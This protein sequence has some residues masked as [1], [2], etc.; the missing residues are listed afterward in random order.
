M[1]KDD[2]GDTFIKEQMRGKLKSSESDNSG[3]K[4]Q[5][6]HWTQ[7]WLRERQAKLWPVEHAAEKLLEAKTAHTAWLHVHPVPAGKIEPESLTGTALKNSEKGMASA[8]A[9]EDARIAPHYWQSGTFEQLSSHISDHD[10]SE[11][12]FF[13]QRLWS[14]AL[15]ATFSVAYVAYK[16]W[17]NISIFASG[18]RST[19]QGM[20]IRVAF[21]MLIEMEEKYKESFGGID[22][23]RDDVEM[24]FEQSMQLSTAMSN[25]ATA[26]EYAGGFGLGIAI[27]VALFVWLLL[28]ATFRR[29]SLNLRR[30]GQCENIVLNPWLYAN[31][32]VPKNHFGSRFVFEFLGIAVANTVVSF[33]LIGYV[34]TFVFTVL[35][36]DTSRMALWSSIKSVYV[37]IL[38]V[39]GSFAAKTVGVSVAYTYSSTAD[40]RYITDQG[41]FGFLDFVLVFIGTMSGY[42]A[43]IMRIGI[44]FITMLVGFASLTTP[45]APIWLYNSSAIGL[46]GAVRDKVVSS[47]SC[48]LYI[49]NMQN[50]PISH[51]FMWQLMETVRTT[52]PNAN[53][54]PTQKQK[55]IRNR[56]QLYV[57][58]AKYPQLRAYR[59]INLSNEGG[60]ASS[61]SPA[62]AAHVSH[63]A[64]CAYE[65][66]EYQGEAAPSRILQLQGVT[67][68]ETAFVTA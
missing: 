53:S 67:T 55:Q 68:T 26:I 30:T 44:S 23:A 50:N 25:L 54:R 11:A 61:P 34:L 62:P 38:V 40:G 57:M 10:S 19:N 33:Q 5:H 6:V 52:A 58:L 18:F 29:D 15:I 65:L 63:E 8:I 16:F 13:P 41:V 35:I 17:T 32:R 66:D 45:V 47:Y 12:F 39:L 49:H 48:M 56:F 2:G 1:P 36:W 7:Q 4:W 43:A 20:P 64:A 60:S 3:R 31:G 22:L 24:V 27:L 28:F 42:V 9:S 21:N 59:A 14:G 37:T 46:L 51:V